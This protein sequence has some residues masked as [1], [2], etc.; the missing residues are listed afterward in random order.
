MRSRALP[1]QTKS[2][3]KHRPRER[4][5]T[6]GS[7]LQEGSLHLE[8]PGL[9]CQGTCPANSRPTP[10]PQRLLTEVPALPR[11]SIAY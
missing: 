6:E 11:N 3:N 4:A 8:H 1:V 5:S 9:H 2:K 10:K 7:L